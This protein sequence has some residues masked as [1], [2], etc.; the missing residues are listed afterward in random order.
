MLGAMTLPDDDTCYRALRARDR[1]FD[2][3][4]FVAVSTTGIYC[5]PVCPARL[6]GRNRCQFFAWAAQAEAAGYRACWRCRPELAP[7]RA[8]VDARARLV[9]AATMAIAGGALQHASA[10]MLAT[11]LG[12]SARHLRRTLR[13]E[14]GV[15]PLALEQTRRLGL[16]RQLLRDTALPVTEV[17]Y[18]SGYASL[19][20]FNAAFV[21]RYKQAPSRLR[22]H[23]GE[24]E[25]ASVTLRLDY[26]APFDASALLSFLAARALRGVEH[27]SR[28]R[29]MRSVALDTHHGWISVTPCPK[30]DALLLTVSTTLLPRLSDVVQR[31]RAL[32]DL[33]A[34]PEAIT[35][36]L[37]CDVAL[38]TSLRR[39]PGLRVPGAFDG[40][41]LALRA[42]LG[43][44]VSVASATTLAARLVDTFGAPVMHAHAD[45]PRRAPTAMELS[46]RSIDDVRAIG[47]P[48]ARA[49][50]I[51]ALARAEANGSL[52]LAA[53]FCADPTETVA[54]LEAVEGIGPWTARYIAMRALRWP[55][56]F[57]AHD[58][59]VR[60]YL[61]DLSARAAEKHAEAWRPWRAYAVMHLWCSHTKEST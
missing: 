38:R 43:Q 60:Q 30:R 53:G 54:R 49:R 57:V 51:V 52:K 32:F 12:V 3:V 5:R 8:S 7:G 6:P 1:R 21:E 14:L 10:D 16:A 34:H 4:F 41:E 2:G 59:V 29:Y 58:L 39:R 37:R 35:A 22:A 48:E 40:F 45:T 11:S 25:V 33:D 50:A 9:H 17:A 46:D 18:A 19:R 55:D 31:V 15:S 13:D 42:V 47:L 56:A 24:R 28:D 61:G 23:R 26:R 20:R 44:Q 27:V 36:T